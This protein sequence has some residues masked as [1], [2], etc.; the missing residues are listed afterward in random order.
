MIIRKNVLIYNYF[1]FIQTA[2][3]P[4][5]SPGTAGIPKD[6]NGHD[7]LMTRAKRKYRQRS[8]RP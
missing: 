6:N 3:P 5:E 4:A 7:S 2:K 1:H 8:M